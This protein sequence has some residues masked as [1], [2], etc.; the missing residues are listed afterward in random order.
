[1]A[2]PPA[3][4]ALLLLSSPAAAEPAAAPAPLPTPLLSAE[5]VEPAGARVTLS[6]A[7][8]GIV[9]PTST[10]RV[11]LPGRS[12]DA[13]LSLLDGADALVPGRGTR[14]VG[15]Q[16]VLTLAPA[17][18]LAPARRYLLRID[19]ARTRDLHD[20][21][22]RAAGPVELHLVV[23]GSAPEPPPKAVRKKRRR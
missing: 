9:E 5:A 4:L 6:P 14:E 2:L 19:G 22:G 20:S 21:A 8:E 15:E 16:T 10:F 23:A 7:T 3:A 13:R 1:M 12:D 17:Q 18:P 11:V